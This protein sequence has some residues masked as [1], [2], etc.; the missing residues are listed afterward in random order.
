MASR[1]ACSNVY[2]TRGCRL[3]SPLVHQHRAL[4][5]HATVSLQRQIEYRIQQRMAWAHECRRRAPGHG[6]PLLLERDAFVALQH[7]F[8]PAHLLATGADSGWNVRYLVAPRLSFAHRAAEFSERRQ[9]ERFHVVRLQAQCFGA[10]HVFPHL[11][12]AGGIEGVLGQRALFDQRLQTRAIHGCGHGLREA[13]AH[14]R[15]IAVADGFD[16]ELAQVAATE[17][18]LAENVEHLAAQVEA[19]LFQLVEQ[20]AVHVSFAG[21]RSDE[22]PQMAYL[23]LADAVDAPKALLQAVGVPRQVVVHHQVGALQV[24]AFAGGVGRQ[25]HVYLAV[26]QKRLLGA[27]AFVAAKAAVDDHHSVRAAQHHAD[28]ALQFVQRIAVFGE[29]HQLLIV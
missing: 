27:A 22:I 8:A 19:G 7:R 28:A 12:D 10:F 9:K 13:G 23:R 17:L 5:Q 15:F 3:G 24:D 18:Q 1:I 4:L 29:H 16:Q 14:R 26:L 21:V 6:Q 25:Q 11:G 2:S 20:G